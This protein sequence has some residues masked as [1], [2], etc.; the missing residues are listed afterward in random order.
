MTGPPARRRAACSVSCGSASTAG[1]RRARPRPATA[2]ASVA[3]VRPT[4]HRRATARTTNVGGRPAAIDRQRDRDGLAAAATFSTSV[5][6]ERNTS[7]RSTT[8]LT[9]RPTWWTV[10]S[11]RTRAARPS[12]FSC[13][14]RVMIRKA[15]ATSPISSS[16]STAMLVSRSPRAT[17]SAPE[18]RFCSGRVMRRASRSDSAIASSSADIAP[19]I[20]VVLARRRAAASGSRS[21]ATPRRPT[22]GPLTSWSCPNATE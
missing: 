11:S 19:S 4:R 15:S 12:W 6:T 20:S 8:E 2:P 13:R 16:V 5:T 7:P 17:A 22:G 18:C 1:V 9:A 10:T 14:L 3:S 21:T